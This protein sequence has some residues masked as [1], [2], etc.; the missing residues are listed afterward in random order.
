EPG[1]AALGRRRGVP[2]VAAV[3]ARADARRAVG[4]ARDRGVE[5]HGR[6]RAG[7]GSHAAGGPARRPQRPAPRAA[8]RTEGDAASRRLRVA[9]RTEAA[10]AAPDR[11]SRPDL[12]RAGPADARRASARP[13]SD[14]ALDPAPAATPAERRDARRAAPRDPRG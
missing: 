8:R 3:A 2:G 14:L 6:R 1:D 7:R 12:P 9:A 13:A 5:G 10:T 4:R 11:R